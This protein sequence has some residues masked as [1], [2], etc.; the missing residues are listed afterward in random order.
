ML[1]L[2]LASSQA[3]ASSV[4]HAQARGTVNPGHTSGLR[5]VRAADK[6]ARGST[7]QTHC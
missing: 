7:F 5:D 2:L 3:Q 1:L 6:R 4:R